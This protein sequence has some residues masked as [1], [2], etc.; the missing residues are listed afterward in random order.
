MGR[1]SAI[2]TS[3]FTIADYFG[4]RALQSDDDDSKWNYFRE[5]D[6]LHGFQAMYHSIYN[7]LKGTFKRR[8]ELFQYPHQQILRR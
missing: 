4:G 3:W 6:L 5:D 2:N 7:H 1:C 8:T